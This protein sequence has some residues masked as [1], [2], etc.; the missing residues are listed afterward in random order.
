MGHLPSP[1]QS[2]KPP[3]SSSNSHKTGHQAN[4]VL[5]NPPLVVFRSDST[6]YTPEICFR[7]P[8]SQIRCSYEFSWWLSC[9]WLGFHLA[10]PLI[11]ELF[12]SDFSFS[13]FEK[14]VRDTLR[15]PGTKW[16]NLQ[17]NYGELF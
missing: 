9:S 13:G 12:S 7:P 11:L 6:F 16:R 14:G 10:F 8:R 2:S 17:V 5:T 3:S 4:S 1:D 15:W